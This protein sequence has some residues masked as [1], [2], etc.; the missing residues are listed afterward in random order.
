MLN[1]S[2]GEH[3]IPT[4][5]MLNRVHSVRQLGSVQEKLAGRTVLGTFNAERI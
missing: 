3:L 1:K 2:T 5:R 4:L